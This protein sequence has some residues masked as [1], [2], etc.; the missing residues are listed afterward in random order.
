MWA[1]F[2]VIVLVQCAGATEYAHGTVTPGGGEIV[3]MDIALDQDSMLTYPGTPDPP[4]DCFK[5]TINLHDFTKGL[6][7]IKIIEKSTC[8]VKTTDETYEDVKQIVDDINK[9]ETAPKVQ[10]TEEWATPSTPIPSEEVVGT[11]GEKIANFCTGYEVYLLE[12]G[13]VIKAAAFHCNTVLVDS[14]WNINI[15]DPNRFSTIYTQIRIYIRNY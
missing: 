5:Q 13:K 7:A 8:F 15:E 4:Q 11:V 10:A 9:G 6:V 1:S 12:D 2:L 14:R 3:P